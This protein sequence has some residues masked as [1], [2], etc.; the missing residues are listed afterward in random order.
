MQTVKADDLGPAARTI[1][2]QE[3]VT[4]AVEIVRQVRTTGKAVDIEDEGIVVA[5]VVPALSPSNQ[6]AD[7]VQFW[8]DM[9]ALS[10]ELS[11]V[12]PA[13]VS[14]EEAV[15]EQRREL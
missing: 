10:K 9:E 1:S 11:A 8:Q 13:G 15:R 14:A 5:R 2:V 4:Q 3:L 6:T 12:W 7:L